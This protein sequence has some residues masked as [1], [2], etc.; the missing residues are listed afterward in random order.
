[1]KELDA[2]NEV[3]AL[4]ARMIDESPFYVKR[5]GDRKGADLPGDFFGVFIYNCSGDRIPC[6][7]AD[8]HSTRAGANELADALNDAWKNHY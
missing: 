7:I 3:G 6:M 2:A 5:L 1:M 4:A 8:Q